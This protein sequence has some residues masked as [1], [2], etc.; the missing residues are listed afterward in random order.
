MRIAY[1][2]ASS[3]FSGGTKIVFLQAEALARRGHHVTVVSP[4]AKPNWFRT[5]RS[6][7]EFASFRESRAVAEADVRVA[8]FWTTVEPAVAGARGAVF[9]LCQGYEGGF[10]LYGD[11]REAI[12]KAYRAPTHKLAISETLAGRL[13]SEG[14]GPAENVGQAFDIENFFP[15][16]EREISS[17][18]VVLVVGPYE[19][20]VKGVDVA[21]A[22]LGLFRSS[23]GA[24]R[25]RRIATV[26]MDRAERSFGLVD[27]YHFR[28]PH[29]RM[30]FAYRSSDIFIGPSRPKEGFGLPVIEALSCGIPT[31]LS[32]TPTNRE[33]A[34]EAAWYFADGTPE[35]L[36]A[37]LP[38]VTTS[39][40]RETARVRG[41]RAAARF[42]T[43]G[44]AERLERAFLRALEH[45]P[46][47]G[48]SR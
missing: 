8:T 45:S 4:Q 6:R 29:E 35:S 33:I 40:A 14:F 42:D 30:P 43:S 47:T 22:G 48:I 31:V 38:Q 37:A 46:E 24:F 34:G 23:G 19:T 20:D 13:I 28:L 7:F 3:E 12:E 39:A 11:R 10:A 25:L 32:D 9:H 16:P 26:E 5:V 21:L 15:G 1:L 18:P 27:E 44:V 41:P 2:I 36:A 17:P